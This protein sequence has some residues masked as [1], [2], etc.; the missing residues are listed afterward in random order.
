MLES[1]YCL[2]CSDRTYS[3]RW[4]RFWD[5]PREY[6]PLPSIP[7]LCKSRNLFL[8]YFLKPDQGLKLKY[9]GPGRSCKW[10]QQAT[11]QVSWWMVSAA[12]LH[13]I[14]HPAGGQPLLTRL[15]TGRLWTQC[16]HIFPIFQ[17]TQNSPEQTKTVWAGFS[18]QAA[19]VS[20]L[21]SVYSSLL[22]ALFLLRV[23]WVAVFTH[24]FNNHLPHFIFI[25][26]IFIEHILR[27]FWTV[28]AEIIILTRVN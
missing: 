10:V 21:N 18:L 2:Q 12:C 20:L 9:I 22:Q 4:G 27:L 28:N 5:L 14:H 8:G 23:I 19:C 15:L 24:S 26:E 7:L 13:H 1:V 3:P 6:S 17:E 16:C 25:Q 11:A